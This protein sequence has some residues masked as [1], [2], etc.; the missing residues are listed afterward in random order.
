MTFIFV[1]MW[2]FI[3]N[4]SKVARTWAKKKLSVKTV[5]NSVFCVVRFFKLSSTLLNPLKYQTN[6]LKYTQ[7]RSIAIGKKFRFLAGLH[8]TLTPIAP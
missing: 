3:K 1:I 7:N 6:H 2:T 8:P 5:Q 4:V